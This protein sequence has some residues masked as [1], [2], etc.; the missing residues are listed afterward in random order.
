MLNQYFSSHTCT[1]IHIYVHSSEGTC[2]ENNYV[3]T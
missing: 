3:Y 2:I 1:E